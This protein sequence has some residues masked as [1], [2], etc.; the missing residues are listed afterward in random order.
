MVTNIPRIATSL[1][2]IVVIS[3]LSLPTPAWAKSPN[4][5]PT[6]VQ[7]LQRMT[8]F[9]S[10]QKL[11][12]VH[13]QT[14]Y[15]DE[16]TSGQRVDYEIS[17]KAVVRR[18]NKIH[19]ERIG[20]QLSQFFYYDG[21]NLTLYHLAQNVYA[22]RAAPESIE[23][24]LDFAREELGLFIP[25]SDLIYSYAYYILMENVNSATVI[26]KT[27]INGMACH[28]LAFR[29]PGVDFQLWV[30]DGKQPL[31]CK[32]VVT[33]TTIPN[34]LSVST[35]MSD[36]NLAPAISEDQFKFKAPQDAH[37]IE[38]MPLDSGHS[39]RK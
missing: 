31:P 11:F 19:S 27:E 16:L 2:I 33:D 32:F 37:Q 39:E 1:F 9:L 7:I 8:D 29:K 30:A 38:F 26:G 14:T 36:W 23:K 10:A 35:V 15:E 20:E 21:K 6:A 18:P 28:H 24:L 22:T 34:Q 13:T 5:D 12:S 17:A 25:A 3:T 4:L